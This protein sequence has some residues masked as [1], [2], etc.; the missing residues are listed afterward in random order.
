MPQ[1]YFDLRKEFLTERG[2]DR[3]VDLREKFIMAINKRSFP[4]QILAMNESQFDDFRNKTFNV[5]E[6]LDSIS[7]SLFIMKQEE[8]AWEEFM[9]K[10]HNPNITANPL[11][12]KIFTTPFSTLIVGENPTSLIFAFESFLFFTDS[13]FEYLAQALGYI[14]KNGNTKHIV[15]LMKVLEGLDNALA[16]ALFNVLENHH[17]LWKELQEEGYR[18][19]FANVEP[20]I[21]TYQGKSLRDISG[22]YRT[23]K[24]SALQMSISP[25]GEFMHERLQAGAFKKGQ[26]DIPFGDLEKGIVKQAEK[27]LRDITLLQEDVLNVLITKS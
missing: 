19:Y 8:K 24:M 25:I 6:R 15:K 27:Y 4:P 11:T 22:H 2:L 7:F 23:L 14:F 13:Y 21:D 17:L 12:E 20:S 26:K 5:F 3:S 1:D 9:K 10:A 16:K 18:N